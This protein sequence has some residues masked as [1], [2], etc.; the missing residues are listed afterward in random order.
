[1]MVGIFRVKLSGIIITFIRLLEIYKS[2]KP[3]IKYNC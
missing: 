2:M 1:V 3:F